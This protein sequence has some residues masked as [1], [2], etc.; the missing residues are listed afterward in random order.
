MGKSIL[1]GLPAETR[2]QILA[3]IKAGKKLVAQQDEQEYEKYQTGLNALK[4][5]IDGLVDK[6]KASG[7]VPKGTTL[8]RLTMMPKTKPT[9][10]STAFKRIFG[11]KTKKVAVQNKKATPKAKAPKKKA[12]VKAKAKKN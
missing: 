10:W 7:S 6:A 5:Q 11:R 9:R 2:K 4:K 8:K 12:K 3:Q 1:S